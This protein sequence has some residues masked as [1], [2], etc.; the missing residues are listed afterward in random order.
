MAKE[1]RIK[2]ENVSKKF[3]IGYKK[4]QGALQRVLSFFSGK[5]SK[6]E[7][8][9]LDGV[10][11]EIFPKEIIGIIGN[12]GS[13]K[14]TLL[15]TLAGIYS[16]D[17]GSISVN[18]K[19]VSLINLNVGLKE[20]L[21]MVEN[22]FLCCSLFGLPKSEIKKKFKSIVEFSELKDF[23]NTK[24]YQFSEGM[25]QRLVFSI[26]IH[27]NPDIFLLDEVLEVGDRAFK[28][29]CSVAINKIVSSGTSVIL[30]SHNLSLIKKHCKRVLWLE[31]GKIRMFE[32]AES[33]LKKYTNSE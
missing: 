3:K 7:I 29:K 4:R 22:I 17:S 10:S 8:L 31:K 24:V 30:V 14:S 21:T 12:N 16:V 28:E 1:F 6:K 25:K 11:F 23:V 9:V 33:V 32:D 19:V 13:G 5:D 20:R 27:C 15:R 26:G 2:V 18:G